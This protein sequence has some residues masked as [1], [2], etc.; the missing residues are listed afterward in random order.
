MPL[1]RRGRPRRL[2][3]LELTHHTDHSQAQGASH[4]QLIKACADWF[5]AS[6]H[7]Q[8]ARKAREEAWKA[9]FTGRKGELHEI[10]DQIDKA[11]A[12]A[13]A[14]GSTAVPLALASP[15][16][17]TTR[18]DP[19]GAFDAGACA[20]EDLGGSVASAGSEWM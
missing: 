9:E 17:S 3:A 14:K 6:H 18:R 16:L 8:L 20:W 1:F 19:V 13:V 5:T 10:F 15:L 4:Q 12:A 11:P 7:L 2:T